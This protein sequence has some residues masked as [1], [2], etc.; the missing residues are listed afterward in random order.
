[1]KSFLQS[2]IFFLLFLLNHLRLPTAPKLTFWQVSVFRFYQLFSS[3]V[4]FITAVFIAPFLSNGSHSVVVCMFVAAGIC[5]PNHC[6]AINVSSDFTIPAFGRDVTI[7]FNFMDKKHIYTSIAVL[8]FVTVYD[9]VQFA[10]RRDTACFVINK[11]IR[12]LARVCT[13]SG[14]N[15]AA[16][17]TRKVCTN[18]LPFIQNPSLFMR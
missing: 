13:T 17:L 3:E 6:L 2:L 11:I 10:Y 7:L 4:F 9:D 15:T 12:L 14:V 8:D 16:A 5:L 18:F 1:M